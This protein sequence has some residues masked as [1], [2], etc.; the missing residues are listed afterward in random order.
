MSITWSP[1]D[2]Q[3]G[4]EFGVDGVRDYAWAADRLGVSKRTISRYIEQ[5][6]FRVGRHPGAKAVICKRSI[7]EYVATLE[8]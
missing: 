5:G 3:Y 6:R 4:Y 8:N 2:R 1:A 7:L